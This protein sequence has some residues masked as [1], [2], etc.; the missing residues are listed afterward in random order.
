[1]ASRS[2]R[3]DELR[4]DHPSA[5]FVRIQNPGFQ[6]GK[7]ADRVRAASADGGEAGHAKV[8]SRQERRGQERGVSA[9][10]L[11]SILSQ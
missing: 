10:W 3:R 8:V 9:D 1:M 5:N 7:T 6:G 4:R 11:L 2:E